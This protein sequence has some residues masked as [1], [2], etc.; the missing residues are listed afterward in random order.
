M[1]IEV[2]LILLVI[3]VSSFLIYKIIKRSDRKHLT[4]LQEEYNEEKDK[5]RKI[6]GRETPGRENRFFTGATRQ[7]NSGSSEPTTI[8]SINGEEKNVR[9]FGTANRSPKENWFDFK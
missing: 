3:L 4:K 6:E 5:S 1:I 8:P 9:S 7:D 2:T